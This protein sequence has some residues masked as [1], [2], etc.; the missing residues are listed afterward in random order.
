M[1]EIVTDAQKAVTWVL[2]GRGQLAYAGL[3][4][5]GTVNTHN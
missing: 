5:L 3:V 1:R 4:F 2:R